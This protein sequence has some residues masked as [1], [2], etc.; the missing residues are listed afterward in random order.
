MVHLAHCHHLQSPCLPAMFA[1]SLCDQASIYFSERG[2]F[3][4]AAWRVVRVYAH[5]SATSCENSQSREESGLGIKKIVVRCVHAEP[6]SHL[7]EMLCAIIICWRL[8]RQ[9]AKQTPKA[10]KSNVQKNKGPNS[11]P[12]AMFSKMY[13]N[14]A[15]CSSSLKRQKKGKNRK[16]CLEEQRVGRLTGE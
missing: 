7:K 5:H 8:P 2:L 1:S 4:S 3:D 6:K 9:N 13:S 11:N 15:R 16:P 10:R 12:D 14:V